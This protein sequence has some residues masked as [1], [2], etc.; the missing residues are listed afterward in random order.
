MF[1]EHINRF[2]MYTNEE[3]NSEDVRFNYLLRMSKVCEEICSLPPYQRKALLLSIKDVNGCTLLISL[4]QLGAISIE[5]L[6]DALD[7]N[8]QEFNLLLSNLPMNDVELARHLNC[9]ADQVVKLRSI[10]SRR[11]C[12]I[13]KMESTE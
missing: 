5:Q 10:S 6:T 2:I 13:L 1:I 4:L 3:S 12:A 7:I 9:R 8:I 11:I